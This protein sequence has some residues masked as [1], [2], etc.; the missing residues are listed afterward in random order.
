MSEV[1]SNKI[2]IRSMPSQIDFIEQQKLGRLKEAPILWTTC[3]DG[4]FLEKA[5]VADRNRQTR[6]RKIKGWLQNAIHDM[7]MDIIG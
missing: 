1:H 5:S 6:F 3:T 4:M 7:H 2:I